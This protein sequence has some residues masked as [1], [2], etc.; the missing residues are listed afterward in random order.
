MTNFS[1]TQSQNDL[2]EGGAGLD[3]RNMQKCLISW[4]K[5]THIVSGAFLSKFRK[6]GWIIFRNFNHPFHF[7]DMG[8]EQIIVQRQ[9][10][11]LRISCWPDYGTP[12]ARTPYKIWWF[13][14]QSLIVQGHFLFVGSISVH[15]HL[16]ATRSYWP[17]VCQY[18][19][20]C[21][22]WLCVVITR[23][24]RIFFVEVKVWQG[25]NF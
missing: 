20:F 23:G 25:T 3:C 7:A 17:D 13:F 19:H 12:V 11:G 21:L 24:G 5:A 18:L 15:P 8:V 14:W 4:A 2:L 16:E 6:Q 1:L 10:S 9:A 22:V